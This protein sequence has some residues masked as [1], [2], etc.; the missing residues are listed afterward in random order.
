MRT[1]YRIRQINPNTK[2]R[3]PKNRPLTKSEKLK[4][5][6]DRLKQ[7]NSNGRNGRWKKKHQSKKLGQR[8]CLSKKNIIWNSVARLK[9][10][11]VNIMV[12]HSAKILPVLEQKCYKYRLLDKNKL[13]FA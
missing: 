9:V 13:E 1:K 7:L 10:V 5:I 8:L 12:K 3:R 4:Q 11:Y 2:V 6:Q